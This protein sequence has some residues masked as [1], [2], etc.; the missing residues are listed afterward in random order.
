MRYG[1]LIS[2]A[3]QKG[4]QAG[5][6]PLEIELLLC[7]AFTIS[8]S[9]YWTIRQDEV[10]NKRSMKRFI[11]KLKRLMRGE[12]LDYILKKREFFSRVFVVDRR[13]LVPRPETEILVEQT[14]ARI[15][16]K[17]T[18]L[19]IGAGSG[20]VSVTLALEANVQVTALEID[21]RARR[22]LQT[23]IG[24]F[25]VEKR[26]TACGGDLFPRKGGPWQIIVAN[27]P[28]LSDA[29]YRALPARI[30]RFEPRRALVGGPKGSEI[31]LRIV[32]GSHS[33][34]RPGGWLVLETGADQ[35]REIATAMKTRGFDPVQIEVDLAGIERVVAGR[36]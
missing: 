29:E 19:D 28:Y 16:P 3:L 9:R 27:P 33:R 24:R 4:C 10:T 21:R 2:D 34:I 36:R 11:R 25:G 20:C 5:I 6:E 7:D 8:R 32:S 30:R 13:V 15:R 17:D 14:L 12:P 23:N 18:V 1:E 22:L 35:A 26:V 31:L